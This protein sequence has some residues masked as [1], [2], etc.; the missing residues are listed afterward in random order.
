MKLPRPLEVAAI[1][2]ITV[3]FGSLLLWPVHA[4]KD[5][6][7]KYACLSNVKQMALACIMYASDYDDRFP[8]RD[9]W[10]DASV[11]YLKDE[12]LLQCNILQ[13]ERKDPQIYGYA[14]NGQLSNAKL[15]R[16][17]DFV[18]LVF[19]S[20]NLA[21]NAS[22]SKG[23]LPNPGRHKVGDGLPSNNVSYADGHAKAIASPP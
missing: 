5:S 11:P 23:S 9:N 3:A 13:R 19:E 18:E 20:M 16:R 2:G 15:P 21:R 1:L 4:G 8:N 12:D 14:F 10:M 6:A 22:G 17:P 7:R